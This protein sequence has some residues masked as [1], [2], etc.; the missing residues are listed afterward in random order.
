MPS[1][2]SKTDCT[3]NGQLRPAAGTVAALIRELGLAGKKI[4]VEKNGEVIPKSKHK[5]EPIRPGDILEI[6]SAVGGG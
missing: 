3:V 1:R 4:A 5:T 2:R 6:V